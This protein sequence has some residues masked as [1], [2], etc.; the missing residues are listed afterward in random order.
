M[1]YFFR[2]PQLAIF[3][4]LFPELRWKGWS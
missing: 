4:M 2:N 1:P 3:A